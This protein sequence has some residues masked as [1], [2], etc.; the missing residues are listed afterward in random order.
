MKK[1]KAITHDLSASGKNVRIVPLAD[2]HIG[3]AQSD[4][5]LIQN[6]LDAIL[7]SPDTYCIVG[8]D[9]MD[10]AIA[11][12]IGDTYAAKLQPME[13][14]EKCVELFAPLA[15]AGKILGVLPGNH[16]NRIYKAAGV[17]M[18]RVFCDQLKLTGLYSETTALY[19]LKVGAQSRGRPFVYTL[20]YTH[21]SGGGRKAGGKINRL[22]DYATIVDADVYVC[23][24][25][26]MP[27]VAKM[28]YFRPC[29]QNGTIARVEKTF[30]NTASALLYGGYGD[31]QGYAPASNAY[32]VIE[33][34]GEGG[35][36]KAVFVTV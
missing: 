14:L 31:R 36:E 8:G 25:T 2:L 5:K 27:A 22:L 29:P 21:G 6:L 16:E 20:Y 28:E 24:H 1:V 9:M 35:N 12:S 32:P 18:T 11:S 26:H 15:D 13:Q 3:D 34:H 17:D 33:L 4:M 19:F 23:C 30:V 7:A 10:S